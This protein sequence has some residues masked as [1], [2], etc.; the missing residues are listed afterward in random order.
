MD[1]IKGKH[2]LVLFVVLKTEFIT[3]VYIPRSWAKM[4]SLNLRLELV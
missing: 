3:C 1:S 4:A 2:S